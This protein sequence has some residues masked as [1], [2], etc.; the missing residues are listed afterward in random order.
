MKSARRA[1]L[2][3]PEILEALAV[4]DH[5]MVRATLAADGD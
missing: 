4:A 5:P 3:D 1:G 2:L